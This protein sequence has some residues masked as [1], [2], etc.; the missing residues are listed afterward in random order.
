MTLVTLLAR[1]LRHVQPGRHTFNPG[2][3]VATRTPHP[4]RTISTTGKM[5]L[6]SIYMHV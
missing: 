3:L 5:Y 2:S 1:E 6:N 4:V